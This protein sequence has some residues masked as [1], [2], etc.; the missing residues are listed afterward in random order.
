MGAPWTR[1]GTVS[2]PLFL[3]SRIPETEAYHSDR[4][5]I[6]FGFAIRNR[7]A[8][9]CTWNRGRVIQLPSSR[10]GC[11]PLLQAC[12]PSSGRTCDKIA[13]A[14]PCNSFQTVQRRTNVRTVTKA[15]KR[16]SQRALSFVAARR[17]TS[18]IIPDMGNNRGALNMT[19]D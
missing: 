10:R 7:L 2:R 3:T 13:Q 12:A 1:D 9:G 15:E 11:A 19:E 6:G 5:E 14:I 17:P 18:R 8:V 4:F 16:N